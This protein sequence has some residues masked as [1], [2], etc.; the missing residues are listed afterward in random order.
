MVIHLKKEM[1][2]ELK[3]YLE[4]YDNGEADP[5]IVWD[6]AKAFLRGKIIA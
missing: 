6:A 2:D 5:V 3:M 4:H 1:A